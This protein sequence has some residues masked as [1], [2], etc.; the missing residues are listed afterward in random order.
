MQ[1]SSRLFNWYT[2]RRWKTGAK[3]I[4]SILDTPLRQ[5]AENSGVDSGAVATK[6]IENIDDNFGFNAFDG[7]YVNMLDAGIIDPTKVTRCALENAGSVASSILTTEV[8]V[9]DKD[10]K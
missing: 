8:I 2:W 1:T 5:I 7:T 6:V 4:Q 3:I 9:A 10:T